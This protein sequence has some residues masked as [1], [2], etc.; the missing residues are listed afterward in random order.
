MEV[1]LEDGHLAAVP[2]RRRGRAG[3]QDGDVL[4]DVDGGLPEHPGLGVVP[5][6]DAHGDGQVAIAAEDVD[7]GAHSQRLRRLDLEHGQLHLHREQRQ[8]AGRQAAPGHPPPLL[9]PVLDV[10]G[11]RRPAPTATTITTLG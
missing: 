4:E 7:G 6:H 1:T 2:G 5:G 3:G 8:P 9:G 11:P 10:P